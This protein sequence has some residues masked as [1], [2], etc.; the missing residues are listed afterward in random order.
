MRCAVG[1]GH[2]QRGVDNGYGIDSVRGDAKHPVSEGLACQRGTEESA[3][4]GG[5]WLTRPLVRE[6]GELRKTSWEEALSVVGE[7][8]RDALADSPHA[9][10][11]LGSG[12]QTNEAAYALGKLARGGFGTRNYDANTTLCMASAV[13]AYYDAFGS[14][15]PPPTYDDV[16]EAETHVVWG[17]NPAVAHP[18][19]FRWIRESADDGDLLAVDPV[20]TDTADAADAHVAPDPGEDLTLARAV[21]ARLVERDAVDEAFVDEATVGFEE[22]CAHLPDPVDAAASA[23]VSLADVDRLADAFEQDCLVY[24]GMGVNQ[25]VNGTA[26]SGALVDLCLATGNLGPGSG[27]F[28]LTGQANSMG[29]RVFS[30]KGS[31]PGH[32]DFGDPEARR[33]VAETWGV[34]VGRLPDDTGP[35]PVGLLD[36]VGDEVEAL[37]CVAT[38]PVAGVPDAENVAEQL[39]EAF[40]VV[41]DAFRSE[42][43]E[44][45]DVVLPAATWGESAGT[46][47]NMERTVS[48]VRPATETP[49]GVRHDLDI[50]AS[51]ADRVVPDLDLFDGPPCDPAAV[52]REACDLTAGTLADCSGLSYTRLDAELAVRWP[53]PTP[54][55]EGG[56]R[57]YEPPTVEDTDESERSDPADCWS[58]PTDSGKARFTSVTGT[59]DDTLV[60]ARHAEPTDEQ[61][62]LTLTTGREKD[63]YNTGVRTR[64]EQSALP[65]ARLAPETLAAFCAETANEPAVA[66]GGAVR[67]SPASDATTT[68]TSLR[69]VS[70]RGDVTV[71][72]TP[73]EAVP[74]GVVWL[75]IHHPATNELTLPAADPRSAEPNL[76][77]CAV[78]LAPVDGDAEPDERDSGG[79]AGEVGE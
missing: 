59:A 28:S 32:R 4:P 16:P 23:G 31:W 43:V 76:K 41:Q 27:P 30:S 56:Y 3:N 20:A 67:A 35:G 62:P 77:Q 47:V 13:T 34:P 70:R 22:L 37:W 55:A 75:P 7:R 53:A 58:F 61:Y 72:A 57:Y 40:L 18:V 29:T 26:T 11:V 8:F 48:R 65:V 10:G 38:N 69:V 54:T 64:D 2:V 49:E 6:A 46:A 45:A 39:D 44:Y 79:E 73:D 74:G 66:D 63:A 78:R 36:A 42:T 24:W 51:V 25:H 33:A 15:A 17:A 21:L 9:V 60:S 52:F 5:D 14:D 68:P 12:Q 50:V 19:M 71:E 1:C